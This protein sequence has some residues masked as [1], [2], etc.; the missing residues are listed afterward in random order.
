MQPH[1][2]M[3]TAMRIYRRYLKL[4]PTH[5]EEY[6]AYLKAKVRPAAQGLPTSCSIFCWA[7]V[8][9]LPGSDSGDVLDDPFPTRDGGHLGGCAKRLILAQKQR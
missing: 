6:I 9:L 8:L 1:I 5:T 4:E 7:C 3:E 2:P